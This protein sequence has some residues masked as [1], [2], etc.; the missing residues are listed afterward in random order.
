MFLKLS[1]TRALNT[2]QICHVAVSGLPDA[3]AV[4]VHMHGGEQKLTGEEA[5]AFL[6]W[7]ASTVE[8]A[9]KKKPAKAETHATHAHAKH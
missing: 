6:D 7:L 1:E 3:A 2:D 8:E 4:C 5:N 9:P